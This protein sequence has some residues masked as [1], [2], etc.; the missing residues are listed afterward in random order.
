MEKLTEQEIEL[1]KEIQFRMDK[2]HS[3]R[4]VNHK[5]QVE[6]TKKLNRIK[7]QIKACKMED[8]KLSA[9]YSKHF[10]AFIAVEQCKTCHGCTNEDC[11]LKEN[12]RDFTT[13]R[14][15]KYTDLPF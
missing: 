4:L 8:E 7:M 3:K 5:K 2:V 12:L 9:Q 10:N 15:G 14:C 11:E 13:T 1:A 6:L